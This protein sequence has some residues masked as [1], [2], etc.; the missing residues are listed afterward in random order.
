M[1]LLNEAVMAPTSPATGLVGV[2]NTYKI[3]ELD[4]ANGFTA[5]P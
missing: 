4:Y 1:C 2:F 5:H 3:Y